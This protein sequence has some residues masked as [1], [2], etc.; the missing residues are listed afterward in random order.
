MAEFRLTPEQQ[1]IVSDAKRVFDEHEDLPPF[2]SPLKERM[3]AEAMASAALAGPAGKVH[4]EISAMT[5]EE[6]HAKYPHVLEPRDGDEDDAE[7][8]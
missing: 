6:V 1:K 4:R 2:S 7:T 8:A 3:Q 5:A